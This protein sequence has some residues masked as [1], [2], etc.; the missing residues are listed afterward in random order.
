[1]NIEQLIASPFVVGAAGALVGLKFVPTDA[2]LWTR[3]TNLLCGSLTAG[4]CAQ[5]LSDW[6]QLVKE[7]DILG[8]AF[9]LGLLGLSVIAALFRA[10]SD[11]KL[12]E[13]VNDWLGRRKG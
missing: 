1:M 5:P 9:A 2:S 3:L 12:G 8:V 4:Y 10:I 11:V 6:V 13:I 7:S